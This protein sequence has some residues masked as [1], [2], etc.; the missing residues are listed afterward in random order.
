MEFLS[1]VCHIVY[2]YQLQSL[3]FRGHRV[4]P[5]HEVWV[6]RSIFGGPKLLQLTAL[7]RKAA[8]GLNTDDLQL[9]LLN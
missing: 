1:I 4:G 8:S 9:A 5:A 3:V 7:L 2:S 6:E